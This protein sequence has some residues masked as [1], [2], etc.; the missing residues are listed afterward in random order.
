[1]C[2]C[3]CLGWADLGGW[4]DGGGV[5]G[6][7][8]LDG[9]GCGWMVFGPRRGVIGVVLYEFTVYHFLRVLAV[10]LLLRFSLLTAF[11]LVVHA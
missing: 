5:G 8:R 2:V 6:G 9:G 7:W 10:H 3:V 4:A 11:L 1:M